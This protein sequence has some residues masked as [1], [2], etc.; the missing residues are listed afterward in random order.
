MAA[1]STLQPG[2]A[3]HAHGTETPIFPHSLRRWSQV[4]ELSRVTFDS[5]C[6]LESFKL[7]FCPHRRPHGFSCRFNMQ[8]K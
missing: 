7:L 5:L 1:C 2:S 6:G 8:A 4:C 3:Q